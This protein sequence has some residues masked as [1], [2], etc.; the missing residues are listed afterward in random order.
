MI[1]LFEI[2]IE[3]KLVIEGCFNFLS[4]ESFATH[5]LL[6]HYGEIWW[7]ALRCT[8]EIIYKSPI[9][10]RYESVVSRLLLV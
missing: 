8:I 5:C 4:C 1:M 9:C 10:A 7:L 2:C 6:C 3:A